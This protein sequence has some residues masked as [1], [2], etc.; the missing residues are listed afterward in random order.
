MCLH[1]DSSA[2]AKCSWL[3]FVF[4]IQQRVLR[5]LRVKSHQPFSRLPGSAQGW[6]DSRGNWFL[7]WNADSRRVER[8]YFG[9]MQHWG[10]WFP[11]LCLNDLK[12]NGLNLNEIAQVQFWR[13]IGMYWH[14]WCTHTH[15]EIWFRKET[16]WELIWWWRCTRLDEPKWPYGIG[17]H[18]NWQVE[19]ANMMH[20]ADQRIPITLPKRQLVN[21]FKLLCRYTVG[22]LQLLPMTSLASLASVVMPC[23]GPLLLV[24]NSC[25]TRILQTRKS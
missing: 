10:K 13:C 14:R 19:F 11:M 12:W 25:K 7:C 16:P 21:S 20:I 6:S 2:F 3:K 15:T 23:A 17:R 1:T 24:L 18:T 8:E 5:S 9:T 22:R 4:F